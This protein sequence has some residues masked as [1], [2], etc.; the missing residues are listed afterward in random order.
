MKTCHYHNH[1]HLPNHQK[2]SD[3]SA[4]SLPSVKDRATWI[5]EW[6]RVLFSDEYR[7][8]FSNDSHR[9]ILWRRLGDRSNTAASVERHIS[10]QRGIVV[11][12]TIAYDRKSPL[13]RIES[14]ITAR[15]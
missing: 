12:G 5:A 14:N 13:I 9:V 1:H 3:Q 15:R 6:H 2:I 4:F 8:C 7:F 11:W 10:R